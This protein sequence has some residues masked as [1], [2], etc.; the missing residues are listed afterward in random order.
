MKSVQNYGAL[1]L[2]GAI[3]GAVFPIT[4]IAVSTGYK[5]FGIM[6]WQMAIAFGLSTLLLVLR[7]KRPHFRRRDLPVYIGVA[8][9]GTVLP[10]WFSY[11]ASA[12]LPAGII[13]IIIALVPLF[14]MPIS[15]AMGFEK[16]SVLRVLGAL[17]G[18]AAI[19]ILIGPDASLPDPSKIGF[20]LVM[21]VAPLLYGM[22][23]N[24]L[25]YMGDR[26][27][28]AVQ[29]LFGATVIGLL[30]SVP[31]AALS[32][33]NITPLQAWAPQHWAIVVGAALNWAAYVGYVWLIRRAGPVFSSQ[34]AYL[35]TGW[36]VVIS[37]LMLGERY[38]VWVWGAL[39]L[40]LL[41]VAL[42]QPRKV[43]KG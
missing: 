42:V 6:V 7:G 18:A 37:M 17:C 30:F 39:G 35:V 24:F 13:S 28:E 25:T 27:L 2:M 38:S 36:G 4:K 16:L 21:A 41:G 5:P 20:V 15:L 14:S 33:Q 11:T 22:E 1:V 40:M 10:N 32:G 23:A 12:Q 26:G 8:L 29:V 31:L 3:W 9:L 19:A 34:V 43:D